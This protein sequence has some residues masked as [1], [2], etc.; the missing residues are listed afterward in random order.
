MSYIYLASPYSHPDPSVREA[1]YQAAL[2]ATAFLTR[3]KYIVYSPIVHFH[4]VA[5]KHK[6]PTD[7]KYWNFVN[8]A[9][10]GKALSLYILR[11]D[12]YLYSKGVDD[13]LML[14]EDLELEIRYMTPINPPIEYIIGPED[15]SL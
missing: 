3:C 10:I 9:M 12:G 6:L 1:R 2:D 11:L 4:S 7:A 15:P 8:D 13:E 14:A 5:L